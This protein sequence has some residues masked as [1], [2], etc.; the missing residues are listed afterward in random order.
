MSRISRGFEPA[1]GGGP[2]GPPGPAGKDGLTIL[3]GIGYPPNALGVDGDF[4]LD[5]TLNI[6]YG[7]KKSSG[8]LG[9]GILTDSLTGIYN[10]YPDLWDAGLNGLFQ[11]TSLP[12]GVLAVA[13]T[14]FYTTSKIYGAGFPGSGTDT[15]NSALQAAYGGVVPSN[16]SFMA[17]GDDGTP[18]YFA[19]GVQTYVWGPGVSI[20]GPA[21]PPGPISPIFGALGPFVNYNTQIPGYVYAV[22]YF[23]LNSF[24]ATRIAMCVK[25]ANGP[26][27]WRLGV[28]ASVAGDARPD[29]GILAYTA[30]I[31]YGAS[32]S[33]QTYVAS[34]NAPFSVVA[35]NYY[36]LAFQTSAQNTDITSPYPAQAGQWVQGYAS[37]YPNWPTI[38]AIGLAAGWG[39]GI[40][41]LP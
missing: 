5:T 12:G 41:L 23:A 8:Y 28:Y 25:G 32:F 34:L 26:T 6:L 4:Y 21:G 7:P 17:Y 20:V 27:N 35:G 16:V 18:N 2:P 1:S 13:G 15:G 38:N 29:G 39:P 36:W 11:G 31:G 30:D 37:T 24:S 10:S 22:R 14:I 3:N 40:A 19:T 33:M 9:F